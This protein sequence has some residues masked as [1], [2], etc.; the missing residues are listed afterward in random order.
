MFVSSTW[1]PVVASCGG[2]K[3]VHKAAP[4]VGSVVECVLFSM[5]A[6]RCLLSLAVVNTTMQCAHVSHHVWG[7]A[8][9]GL[10]SANRLGRQRLLRNFYSSEAPSLSGCLLN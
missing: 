5:R 1:H 7:R 8:F 2:A 4:T 3:H 10:V 9:R 6:L